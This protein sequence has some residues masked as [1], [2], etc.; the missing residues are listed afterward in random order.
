MSN[1]TDSPAKHRVL[2]IIPSLVVGGAERVMVHL[3][4]NLDRQHFEPILYLD[5]LEGGLL[6]AIH[7]DVQIL[8]PGKRRGLN[9][10]LFLLREI[11]RHRPHIVFIMMLPIA[12]LASRLSGTKAIT[13]LRETV[14]SP[15]LE[16]SSNP[17]IHWLNRIGVK[18]C[19][20]VIAPAAGLKT[21][22][23]DWYG[24]QPNQIEVINNPVDIRQIRTLA[25]E[26][27]SF[28]GAKFNLIAVGRLTYQKGFDLL[29]EA[30][31][32]IQ[33]IPWRLRILGEGE[34]KQSLLQLASDYNVCKRIEFLGLR[35]NP[36]S[37]MAHSDLLILPS[38][39]E[40]FPNVLLEAMACGVPVLATRCPTGPDEI[41]TA[42]INGELCD[43][44]PK[45]IAAAVSK[46][47]TDRDATKQLAI[48]ASERIKRF[49]LANILEQ[50]EAFLKNKC[51]CS[52]G[53]FE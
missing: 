39:W 7:E 25:Q 26:P 21:H 31:A 6:T 49:D 9:K 29:I 42:G 2:M 33:D 28:S 34:Q 19:H 17:F 41:I 14:F 45:S 52:V 18:S 40:G 8:D 13:I 22:L 44:E 1:N 30:L 16:Q 43:I 36:Y 4:N 51:V 11:R 3:V 5:K 20:H 24:L 15:K 50:Y 35:S 46:L 23:L 53:R 10:I 12:A 37:Y 38:R 27:L 32:S 47:Y 48:V